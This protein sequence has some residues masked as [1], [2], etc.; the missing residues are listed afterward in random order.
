MGISN[1]SNIPKDNLDNTMFSADKS[2]ISQSYIGSN[3]SYLKINSRVSPLVKLKEQ[4]LK[5]PKDKVM[6]FKSSI[7][8]L[9][10]TK[11]GQSI[12]QQST[13]LKI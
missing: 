7:Q 3:S 1:I 6:T 8:G 13:Y 4:K 12:N 9:Q 2:Y 11:E 5:S 10:Q